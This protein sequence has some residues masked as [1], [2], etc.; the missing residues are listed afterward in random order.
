MGRT[1]L[2]D[3]SFD[4]TGPVV[5]VWPV[6]TQVPDEVVKELEAV[7]QPEEQ[8]RAAQFRF[9]RKSAKRNYRNGGRKS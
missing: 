1:T 3:C 2:A 5:H 4:L 7:L 6:F 9:G 8:C